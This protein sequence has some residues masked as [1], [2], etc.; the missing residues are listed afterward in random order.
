M[1]KS[2]WF[3]SEREKVKRYEKAFTGVLKDLGMALILKKI[4]LDEGIFSIRVTS[5]GPNLCILKDLVTREVE[6]FV[7]E[8]RSWWEKWF[9]SLRPWRSFD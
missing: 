3:C 8:R 9:V 1:A 2:L 4:F 5:L 7:E 6:S